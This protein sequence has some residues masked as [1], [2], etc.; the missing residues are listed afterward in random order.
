MRSKKLLYL[1]CAVLVLCLAPGTAFGDRDHHRDDDHGNGHGKH[2]RDS[3]RHTPS[4][5]AMKRKWNGT[6]RHYYREHDR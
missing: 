6:K 2:D 4:S 3:D 5:N 1:A